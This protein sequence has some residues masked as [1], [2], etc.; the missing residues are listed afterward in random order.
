MPLNADTLLSSS[1]KSTDGMGMV[2][3]KNIQRM[4][5]DPKTGQVCLI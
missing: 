5:I 3:S 4:G 1:F 2:G